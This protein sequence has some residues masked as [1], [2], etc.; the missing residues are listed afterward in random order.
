MRANGTTYASI[1][2][3]KDQLGLSSING[4]GD[5]LG[6]YP[7]LG[8][9]RLPRSCTKIVGRRHRGSA[10]QEGAAGREIAKLAAM[11]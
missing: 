8:S 7:T 5:K 1:V 4:L 6:S 2:K 9:I 11:D 10:A 3:L